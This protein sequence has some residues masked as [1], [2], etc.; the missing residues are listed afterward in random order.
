MIQH[1][2]TTSNQQLLKNISHHSKAVTIK[3][4]KWFT[5]KAGTAKER[6]VKWVCTC[7]W[8]AWKRISIIPCDCLYP[9][10]LVF[11]NAG[12]SIVK[13]IDNIYSALTHY[14]AKCSIPI[15]NHPLKCVTGL[16]SQHVTDS[17]LIWGCFYTPIG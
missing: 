6:N 5:S 13:L 9:A 7:A 3:L 8:V 11:S 12:L 2:N 16:T 10:L 1:Y 4:V 15:Y 17:F 14:C